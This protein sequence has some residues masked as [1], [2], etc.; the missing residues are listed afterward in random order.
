MRKERHA[1][2]KGGFTLIEILVV[3]AII[4]LLIS[5][6]LPSLNQAHAAARTAYCASN[7]HQFSLAVTMWATERKG[8]I[9]RGTGYFQE[10]DFFSPTIQW[11]Q[12]VVRMFG[13]K[14]N[15]R[16]NFNRVPV[17]KIETFQCPQREGTHPGR[18][19]DY[20]VNAI[21]HR[22]PIK[23]DGNSCGYHP[24]DG[25][26]R[27]VYGVTKIDLWKRPSEVVYIIDAAREEDNAYD[28]PAIGSVLKYGREKI[29]PWRQLEDITQGQT[30]GNEGLTPPLAYYDLFKAG[31]LPAYPED[32]G[33][34]MFSSRAALKMH[35]SGSNAVFVDGHVE[36]IKPPPRRSWQQVMQYYLVKFGVF[37]A[38]KDNLTV[39][40]RGSRTDCDLGDPDY[41]Y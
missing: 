29:E 2:I 3:V 16:K 14:S 35:G 9:P 37:H 26:W 4:A 19:L 31:H 11:T 38:A 12:L 8:V 28:D 5:I 21:D 13:D 34:G 25:L 17:D 22:G 40:E 20:V 33:P 10:K 27:E 7:E 23:E 18:F 30:P 6:L 24:T 41:Q 32:I 1:V 15:Y 36:L 39:L